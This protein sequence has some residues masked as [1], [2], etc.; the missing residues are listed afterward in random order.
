MKNKIKLLLLFV[1]LILWSVC[2]LIFISYYINY[3]RGPEYAKIE[4]EKIQKEIKDPVL[5]EKGILQIREKLERNQNQ[6]MILLVVIAFWGYYE[7]KIGRA[8]F[9][10]KYG[11]EK[12]WI[13][14]GNL[15]YK[16][17]FGG[18]G[19][20]KKFDVNFITSIK[21][22]NY[23]EQDFFQNMSRSF[24]TLSG[25]SVEFSY[26]SKVLRFGIQLNEK[27]SEIVAKEIKVAIEKIK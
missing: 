20:V 13:K 22:I 26:H 3:S 16:K 17:E 11:F 8:Y 15:F 10:R 14:E 12:I 19:K 27:E 21:V 2:G 1:W 4:Y 7:F 5:K 9:F 18:R 25:E 6:R 23:I 24:W